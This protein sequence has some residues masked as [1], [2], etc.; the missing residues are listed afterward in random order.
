MKTM[1]KSVPSPARPRVNAILTSFNRRETTLACLRALA[2]SAQ[3]ARVDLQAI[4]VDDASTDGTAAAVREAFDWVEV[5]EGTGDLFWNRGMHVGYERAMANLPDYFL[6]LND[7]TELYPDALGRLISQS[8]M[9]AARSGRPVIVVGST[10]DRQ[11]GQL[12][13][14]GYV[15][16]SRLHRFGYRLVWNDAR[17]IPCETMNGNCVLIQLAIARQVGNLDP[18]YEHAMGDTDYALR[19]REAGFGVFVA[20][21]VMGR[22]SGNPLAGSFTDESLPWRRRWQLMLGRKGL[23]VRSWLHFTRRH[24]GLMWPLYFAWPYAKLAVAGV[25]RTRHAA[26]DA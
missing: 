8:E 6:W 25:R 7:D 24:G 1:Q 17:P 18:V 4:L 2:V 9:L 3:S 22:C 12:T 26:A 16:G 20:A 11:S 5:I 10:V 13:Y 23:P 14:G 21:G 15:S 19:A